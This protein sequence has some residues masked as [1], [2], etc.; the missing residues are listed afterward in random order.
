MTHPAPLPASTVSVA[1]WIAFS[2]ALGALSVGG[3]AGHEVTAS[4]VTPTLN[5]TIAPSVNVGAVPLTVEFNAT[6]GGGHTPYTYNFSFGDGST[7]GESPNASHVYVVPGTYV[8]TVEATDVYGES[9]NASVTIV[10][11]ASLLSAQITATPSTFALG[12]VTFLVANVTGGTPPYT[13]AWAGLPLGCVA[14]NL[15]SIRCQPTVPGG[16]S[17][18]VTV[19]DAQH[20][21]L[22]STV[23]LVVTGTAPSGPGGSGGGGSG[24]GS[25][26]GLPLYELLSVVALAVVAGAV[27]GVL[28]RRRRQRSK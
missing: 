1:T 18:T 17:V 23:G 19:S 2:L 7:M 12:N 11:T 25:S 20:Q 24:D 10:V 16:F 3:A 28:V 21:N 9:G 6:A 27:A 13:Y 15:Q 26:G 4:G 22:T 5:V 14:G 8:A